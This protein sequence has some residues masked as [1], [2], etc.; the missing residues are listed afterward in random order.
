MIWLALCL[1]L[2]LQGESP[3]STSAVEE[4]NPPW[5]LQEVAD[6]E[7][8][9][10]GLGNLWRQA[11]GPVEFQRKLDRALRDGTLAEG[12]L[13]DFLGGKEL[14]PIAEWRRISREGVAFPWANPET[15]AEARL[16][17][18]TYSWLVAKD[19]QG[20]F[21]QIAGQ[22]LAWLAAMATPQREDRIYPAKAVALGLLARTAL[23]TA[24]QPLPDP[25]MAQELTGEAVANEV[26]LSRLLSFLRKQDSLHP[27]LPKNAETLACCGDEW[28][29][30][31]VRL[32]GGTQEY[33]GPWQ[34]SPELRKQ[35][36]E[37]CLHLARLPQDPGYPFDSATAYRN[38]LRMEVLNRQ[39]GPRAFSRETLLTLPP[40][41]VEEWQPWIQRWQREV[42]A[43][44]ALAENEPGESESEGDWPDLLLFLH[45]RSGPKAKPPAVDPPLRLQMETWIQQLRDRPEPGAA[46]ILDQWSSMA[47]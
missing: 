4:G 17:F 25:R 35:C 45:Q 28:I 21:T 6:L 15:S 12:W 23:F 24:L 42:L 43:Q 32:G 44:A 14:T 19:R 8:Y 22:T 3:T 40:Q 18:L 11:G 13:R 37:F 36:L 20:E 47:D 39:P 46:A 16:L 2:G 33:W 41:P 7:P 5:I 31:L 29:A 30:K 27:Y 34:P 38:R 9:A 1:T 26:L 10:A